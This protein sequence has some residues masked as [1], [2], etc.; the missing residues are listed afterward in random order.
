MGSH[1]RWQPVEDDYDE[2]RAYRMGSAHDR[3]QE[4]PWELESEVFSSGTSSQES[5]LF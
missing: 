3:I 2:S 1:P 4:Q 5:Q